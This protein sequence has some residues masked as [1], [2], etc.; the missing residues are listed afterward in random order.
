MGEVCASVAAE[1]DALRF[2]E[3][4]LSGPSGSRAALTVDDPVA[5]KALG[6]CGHRPS[7]AACVSGHAGQPGQLS[8]SCDLPRR[9][10]RDDAPNLGVEIGGKAHCGG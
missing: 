6:G 9:Y 7:H 2:E 10:L 8:V 5:G 1:A 4:P 3:F